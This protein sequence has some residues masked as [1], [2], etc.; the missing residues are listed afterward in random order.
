[1]QA[2]GA[3][4]G[5]RAEGVC[6]AGEGVAV[7]GCVEVGGAFVDELWCCVLVVWV[8]LRGGGTYGCWVFV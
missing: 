5:E 4:G 3:G 2:G 8:G 6:Y 1:M 7:G